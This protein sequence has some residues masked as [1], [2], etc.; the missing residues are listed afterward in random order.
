MSWPV[1]PKHR[2]E[3]FLGPWFARIVTGGLSGACLSASRPLPV[4]A[5]LGGLGTGYQART[6]LP[7]GLKVKDA[8]I[9][10]PEDLVAIGQ[11]YL[12]IPLR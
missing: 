8:F 6:R 1:S 3:R 12:F 9:A 5:V 10:V 4:G 11:A 7:S 2:G